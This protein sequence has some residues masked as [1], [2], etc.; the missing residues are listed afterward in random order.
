MSGDF[1]D[2]EEELDLG[3]RFGV[4]RST[5]SKEDQEISQLEAKIAETGQKIEMLRQMKR[6]RQ[7]Q[8]M[9]GRGDGNV[10]DRLGPRGSQSNVPQYPTLNN[11]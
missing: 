6:E 7:L 1:P 4:H 2:S 3:L 9:S 11:K 5:Q 8:S 10:K